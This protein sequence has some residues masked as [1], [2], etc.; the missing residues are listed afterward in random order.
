MSNYKENSETRI[1]P[2]IQLIE[3]SLIG[4]FLTFSWDSNMPE[5][6]VTIIFSIMAFY[7]FKRYKKQ[8]HLTRASS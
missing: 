6:L 2:F 5:L 4:W 8:K 1:M 3:S 7:W